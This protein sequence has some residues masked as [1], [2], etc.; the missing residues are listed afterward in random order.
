MADTHTSKNGKQI[1]I[2]KSDS[3][4]GG[5]REGSGKESP[6]GRNTVTTRRRLPIFYAEN[7][8]DIIEAIEMMQNTIEQWEEEINQS[9]ERSTKGGSE[10]YKKAESLLNEMKQAMKGIPKY[11]S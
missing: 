2:R 3:N 11:W 5:K 9:K 1:Y 6:W 8:E 10:R 4:W 7:A